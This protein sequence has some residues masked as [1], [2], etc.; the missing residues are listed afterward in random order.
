VE[1]GGA[2]GA[3]MD[4]NVVAVAL[5]GDQ[6]GAF[7]GC[8][9]VGDGIGA[10]QQVPASRPSGAGLSSTAGLMISSRG[11]RRGWECPLPR[12]VTGR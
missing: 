11:H 6:A 2:A 8:E 4:E 10:E 3:A 9:V 5:S 12:V 7:E 1:E